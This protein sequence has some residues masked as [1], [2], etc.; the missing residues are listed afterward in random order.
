MANVIKPKRTTTSGNVP[1]TSEIVSG[2]I[3]VNLADKKLYVRDTG[4]NILELTTRNVTDLDDTTI[5]SVANGQVLKYHAASSKWTN[6]ADS[7]GEA[8]GTAVAMAIAL[9]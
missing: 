8:G 7:E 1:T 3:A 4:T 2:E 6:Q 9:G 5:T